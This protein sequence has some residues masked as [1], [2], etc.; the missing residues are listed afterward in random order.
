MKTRR[1]MGENFGAASVT[2][3]NPCSDLS[4]VQVK[5]N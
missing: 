5:N 4:S 2:G 1:L 3:F